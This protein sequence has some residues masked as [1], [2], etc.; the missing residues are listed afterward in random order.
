MFAIEL[1]RKYLHNSTKGIS[2]KEKAVKLAIEQYGY[3]PDI[4][5]QG[6]NVTVGMLAEM[7]TMSKV[8][9]FWWD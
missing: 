7:L 3:C 9:F 5:E 6:D 4:V 2:N 1:Y 8:W